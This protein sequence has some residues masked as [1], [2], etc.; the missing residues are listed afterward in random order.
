MIKTP[1]EAGRE[2]IRD[3]NPID[4]LLRGGRLQIWADVDLDGIRKLKQALAKYEEL[5]AILQ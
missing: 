3:R 4:I 1:D 5:L 2:P